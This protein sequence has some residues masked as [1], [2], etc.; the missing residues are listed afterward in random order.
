MVQLRSYQQALIE[1]IRKKL[2]EQASTSD[3]AGIIGQ[4]PTGAGKSKIF[5]AIA[6]MAAA[7]G[8]TTLI[9]TEATK[10]F[11][12][13]AKEYPSININAGTRV[14]F[15]RPGQTYIAMAQTLA[16]RKQLI[17][18]FAALERNLLIINDEAHIGTAT[19]LL[20]QLP[21]AFLVGFT[22]TPAFKWAKHLPEL[23]QDIAVGPQV[24]ELVSG[25]F[26]APYKHFARVAANM[27]VLQIERGEFTEESQHLAFESDKVYDTLRDDLTTLRFVKCVVFTS[28]ISH[29]E[30]LTM[31]LKMRG[32]KCVV[33]H[34]Q[35]SE[36]QNSYNM[37][38]FQAPAPSQV[39]VCISVGTLTKGFDFPPI[40]LVVLMR[41]TTSLPL[42]LQMIGR[43]SRLSQGKQFFTTLDYGANYKRHGLWS[44]DRD[45]VTLWQPSKTKTREAVAPVKN[46]PTCE[47][48]VPAVKMICPNCGHAFVKSTAPIDF[49][50]KLVDVTKLIKGKHIGDLSAEDLAEAAKA[51]IAKKS[52]AIR[53]AKAREQATPGFLLEFAKAM[54]YKPSWVHHQEIPPE[55]IEF[56][57]KRL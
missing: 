33:I 1:S 6:K 41:A 53:V 9:L 17:E 54:G 10:I 7:N 21:K 39:N 52:Y 36:A 8:T 27:D 32:I 31:A 2:V 47:Y 18:Q 42:Y 12:Q 13:I 40:D 14:T 4:A 43:G 35:Q 20:K 3:R 11:D 22:A 57:N 49:E 45:W 25:G 34:S 28:S 55:P 26:L 48:I 24:A 50:T 23:Y 15:I 44:D 37:R 46:C 38:E 56:Y 16:R 30:K 5:I 51:N 19:T 29:C